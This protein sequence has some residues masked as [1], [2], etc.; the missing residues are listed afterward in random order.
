MMEKEKCSTWSRLSLWW[1]Q[2]ICEHA[3]KEI[4]VEELRTQREKY[5]A[6]Y[7]ANF[8]YSLHT[9]KCL[10]CGK[11]TYSEKRKIHI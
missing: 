3:Y 1:R 2:L 8:T 4:S 5:A 10:K 9:Y 6:F 11:V 7:Y